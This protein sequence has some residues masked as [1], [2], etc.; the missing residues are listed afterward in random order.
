MST[1]STSALRSPIE[2]GPLVHIVLCAYDPNLEYLSRQIASIVAQTYGN[3]TCEVRLDPGTIDCSADIR[4]MLSQDSRFSFI[5]APKRLG[6]YHNFEAGLSATPESAAFVA[7]CDQ[8]DEWVPEK[9]A[10][11]LKAF[12]DLDV[13]LVHSDL[14]AIDALG[15][16]L[17][18]SCFEVEKRFTSDVGL[19][20]LILRNS[21]TGCACVIRTSLLADVLPFPQQG[22]DIA[23]H[24]DLWTALVATQFG[25]IATLARPLVRYRQHGGN[26]V[27]VEAIKHTGNRAPLSLQVRSWRNNWVLREKLVQAVLERKLLKEEG[28]ARRQRREIEGWIKSKFFSFSLLKRT[29]ILKIRGFPAGDA[30]LQTVLGKLVVAAIPFVRRARNLRG[31]MSSQLTRMKIVMKAGKAFALESTYRK[32]VYDTLNRIEPVSGLVSTSIAGAGAVTTPLYGEQYLAPLALTFT[33]LVPRVVIVVPTGRVDYIFG[34]LTTIFKFGVALAQHGISVRFVSTDHALSA[35]DV[36]DLREFLRERCGF[37]GDW[38]SIEIAS[39]V[40]GGVHAHRSDIFVATI[41]W[42]ARRIF[43]TLEQNRFQSK[44]FYYFIQDYEPGFYAWSN[45]YALAEST[46]SMTCWPIVN[47]QFLAD[48]LLS[49]TGLRTPKD[50]VFNPEIDWAMFYPAGAEEI[51]SRKIKRLFFYG[52]PGTPRNLFDVGLAAIRRFLNELELGSADIAVVSAGEAHAPIDL[53]RGVVMQSVGKLNMKE[54]AQSLRASDIGLSLMLSPHP[55]YPPFEMAA[56]GL[57]V[58]TNNF[59]TKHMDFGGNFLSTNAAPETLARAL[60]KA[61][62]RSSDVEARIAGAKIDTSKLGRPLKELIPEI[63]REMTALLEAQHPIEA[64][65]SFCQG[66]QLHYRFGFGDNH[67]YASDRVCLFSHFDVDN[68]IDA[69]VINYLSALKA[70]GF[71]IILITSNLQL[72]KASVDEARSICS[73]LIHRENRG[74]DFAGWAL[75]LRLVPSLYQAHEVLMCNDSVYGPLH[76]LHPIFGKMNEVSCDFWGVTESLEVEWH[77]Q[78]YFLVFKKTALNSSIFS[79]FWIAVKALSDKTELIHAYEVPMA[80]LLA[81]GGLR[82]GVLV[83][84]E[85]VSSVVCNPT[86]NPWRKTIVVGKSPFVKVQLLRDN[87]L[88][89]DIKNWQKVVAQFGYDPNMIEIHL[90]RVRER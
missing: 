66:T 21:I 88:G 81:N 82:P 84:L 11:I 56:S 71:K 70:E 28:T 16:R 53:G 58:V 24:H 34:G 79:Q 69:H 48:H 40:G 20:Q 15:H 74:Y 6:V 52:R 13:V 64:Q 27:G 18:R 75:A 9:L 61:W 25:Q 86:L 30:G 50:R 45:E 38:Q 35:D 36:D 73:A 44:T 55:S 57:T 87:P 68:K 29:L 76:S 22:M 72:E 42:S 54:Y 5:A 17:Y 32:K 23:F 12:E 47:T 78:S 7:F 63:A 2:M 46:Y 4:S 89:S 62:E 65:M 43:H 37:S 33:A 10:L 26:V 59:S 83:A 60:T 39:S 49:E 31:R 41:W 77:L 3:W 14:E 19:A 8:D 90:S 85:D 67:D 80:R 51:Q 1:L